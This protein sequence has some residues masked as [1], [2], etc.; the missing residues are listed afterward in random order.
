MVFTGLKDEQKVQDLIA[1]LKQFDAA[2]KKAQCV[3]RY[4]I[5]LVLCLLQ[6]AVQ[7]RGL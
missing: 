6:I 7:M 1:F 4:T 2:G 3:Y 5:L